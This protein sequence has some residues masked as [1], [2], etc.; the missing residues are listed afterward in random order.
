M[1]KN[2]HINLSLVVQQH[3]M[4]TTIF[5][6]ALEPPPKLKKKKMESI[7]QI[8]GRKIHKLEREGLKK[9]EKSDCLTKYHHSLKFGT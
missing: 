6:V 8:L 9:K 2:G 7:A 3:M 1:E 4:L 5:A